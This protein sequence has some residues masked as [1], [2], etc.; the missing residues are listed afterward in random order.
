[1]TRVHIHGLTLGLALLAVPAAFA[2]TPINQTHPLDPRGHVEIDNLK[3]SIDVRAWDRPEVKIEGVLGNG[4]EKL[5]IEGD[6]QRLT[7]RVKYPNRGGSMGLFGGSDKSEPTELRL[8]VPLRADLEIDSVSADVNVLGVASNELSI[9]SVSGDVI[10]AAA[11]QEASVDSVSGD[12]Q[13][14][15]NSR[16][17]SAESVSGDLNLRGRLDGEVDVETVSGRIDVAVLESRLHKLTG[18]SVSGDISITTALT[19]NGRISLETVS[20]D[21]HLALPRDLSA[22]VRGESFSGDLT[23][24]DAQVIRPKHGPGSSFEHRY[25]N[26]DGDITIETFSGDATLQLD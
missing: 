12:L 1:M 17:V 11:P 13:L 23:A 20:G 22:N 3:G 7:I 25:G 19:N 9:D 26:G 14:T 15:L 16:R 4:V 6:Q 10:V 8:M 5:E 18:S 2:G 24:P 21:L